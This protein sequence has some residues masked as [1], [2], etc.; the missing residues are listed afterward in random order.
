MQDFI[1]T[2]LE[3]GLIPTFT[4]PTQIAR[5][6]DTLIDIILINQRH[7]ENHISHVVVDNL[8]DHLPCVSVLKEINA[9]KS[10][11]TVTISRDIRHKNILSLKEKLSSTNWSNV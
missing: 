3:K 7:C 5:D 8:N 6:S 9:I 1:E 11:K 10:K 2:I 4:R